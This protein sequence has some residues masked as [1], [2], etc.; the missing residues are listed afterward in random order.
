MSFPKNLKTLSYEE[1]RKILEDHDQRVIFEKTNI[2]PDSQD[3]YEVLRKHISYNDIG[4]K[5]VLGIDIFKYSSY[6]VFEQTLIPFLFRTLFK[7]ATRLCLTNHKF[8]FQNYDEEHFEKNFISTGDGGYIMFDTPLHSLLFAINFAVM[9]RIYNA[10]HLFPR[11]RRVIG[12]V[13]MRYAITLDKIYVFENNFYGRGIIN[14]ARILSKDDLNRCLIDENVHSWFTINMEGVENLQVITI[15]DI[16]NIYD[17]KS[18]DRS[19]LASSNDEIFQHDVT[20]RYGIINADILKIGKISS[21]ETE[22]SI[23][24]LHLQVTLN[25]TNDDD[26]SQKKTITFSLGN[27]NTS[28]I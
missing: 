8:I 3:L 7:S 26:P 5:S 22:L 19:M 17:F 9:L 1:L 12:G 25:L 11:L 16:A 24:N 20:R 10:Y 15:D 18:Y 27:L 21:K 2:I 28:G 6:G 14:C 4:R 23:Y 13:S